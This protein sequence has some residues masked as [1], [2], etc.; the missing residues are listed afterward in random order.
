MQTLSNINYLIQYNCNSIK[1]YLTQALI[2]QN[3]TKQPKRKS[4]RKIVQLVGQIKLL[5]LMNSLILVY[6]IKVFILENKEEIKIQGRK[7][8]L[9]I[10]HQRPFNWKILYRIL[11]ILSLLVLYSNEL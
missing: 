9:P 5:T 3:Q 10:V 1:Q 8:L 6:S 11:N 2:A 7:V 4:Q